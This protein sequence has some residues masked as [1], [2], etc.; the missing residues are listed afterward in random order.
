[1]VLCQPQ[2]APAVE[3]A[4]SG[5]VVRYRRRGLV[6]GIEMGRSG[7]SKGSRWPGAWLVALPVR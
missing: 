6:D 5:D 7:W 4:A 3:P 2:G 1:M